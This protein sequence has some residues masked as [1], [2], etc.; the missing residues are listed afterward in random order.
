MRSGLFIVYSLILAIGSA[1]VGL[2]IGFIIAQPSAAIASILIV[3]GLGLLALATLI[4]RR[5]RRRSRATN[6]D[7]A[8]D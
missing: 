8:S 1:L 6:D 5:Y 4:A 7:Q 2:V 3:V